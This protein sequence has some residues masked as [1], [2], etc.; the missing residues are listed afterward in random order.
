MS[1]NKEKTRKNPESANLRQAA[2]L[3]FVENHISCQNYFCRIPKFGEDILNHGRTNYYSWK[4]SSTT[5]LAVKLKFIRD[6][7]KVNSEI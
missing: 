7:W 5:V 6:V 2:V 1:K 4:I 3:N